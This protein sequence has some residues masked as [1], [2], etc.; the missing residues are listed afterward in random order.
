MTAPLTPPDADLQDFPFMLLHVARLRD[1]DLAAEAHPEA[2]WYAVMLWAAS[3]HQLPAGS[4]PNNDTVLARLCGLGRD[5]RTF[6]R[7]RA[8]A[9]RG[10]VVCDDGRLYHPVVAEQVVAAWESKRQQRWRS[11]CARIKK[12]NQR[13]GTDL[14]IP[15]YEEFI[16]AHVPAVSL[17]TTDPVPGDNDECPPGQSLQETGTGTGILITAVDARAANEPDDWP[18]GKPQDH[19][20]LL[21]AE[22]ATVNL[23]LARQPGLTTTLGRLHAWRIAGASWEHDVIPTVTALARKTRRPIASW[24]FFDDAV[25]QAVAD[26]RTALTIPEATN[27]GQPHE[28]RPDA[29]HAA[30]RAN[31]DRHFAGSEQALGVVAARRAL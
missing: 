30:K 2:C 7:H 18:E 3:W 1:S 14:P 17:G 9:L 24:K 8:D 27:G 11:E 23:D 22:A 21:C 20:R 4:L 25:A 26:N 10:F 15:T 12:A 5:L 19:A 16:G 31:L 29:R 28:H 6:K 13:N